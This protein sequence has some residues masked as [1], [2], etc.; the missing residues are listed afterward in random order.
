M[1]LIIFKILTGVVFLRMNV[2]SSSK[3][4]EIETCQEN[5]KQFYFK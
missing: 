4:N 3:L 2:E 1:F 5:N